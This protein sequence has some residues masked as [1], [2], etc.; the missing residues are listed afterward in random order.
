MNTRSVSK[1]LNFINTAINRLKKKQNR[2]GDTDDV[3]ISYRGE[4][5]DFGETS[6][7]P[8][9]FRDES[10]IAKEK[11]LFE[12]I[13]DYKFNDIHYNKNIDKAIEAQHYMAISRMLDI[14]FNVLVAFYFA[15]KSKEENDGFIYIFAFPDHYSPHSGYIEEFY[16]NALKDNSDG[17]TYARN[18]KV[19]S[20][21]YSNERIKAQKGGFVFFPGS[22]FYPLSEIYY[23]KVKIAAEDK[24]F[25]IEELDMLFQIND[26]TIFPEKPVL[27]EEIKSK[28]QKKNYLKKE[29]TIEEEIDTLFERLDFE[30]GIYKGAKNRNT[31]L[32][33]LRKEVLDLRQYVDEKLNYNSSLSKEDYIC[34]MRNLYYLQIEE[35]YKIAKLKYGGQS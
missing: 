31:R 17:I 19:F 35:S 28:F 15:C 22:S 34:E 32:R 13:D 16:E 1:Y 14:T 33:I 2:L 27:A 11:Y 12:L 4:P 29:V 10:H 3:M 20:H 21:S 6:L 7:M 24:L 30:M 8:S 5:M 9:I 26:A 25:L 18:F 23:E